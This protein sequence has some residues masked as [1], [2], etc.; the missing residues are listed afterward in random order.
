MRRPI[1]V[2]GQWKKEPDVHLYVLALIA[3]ARQ[4]QEAEERAKA[5]GGHPTKSERRAGG[6][7]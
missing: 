4:L 7:L 3:L 2:V 6:E 5:A 1:R